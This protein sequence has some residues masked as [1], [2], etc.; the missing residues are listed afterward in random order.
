MENKGY[1]GIGIMNPKS[2]H[3]KAMGWALNLTTNAKQ[4]DQM[5]DAGF[6]MTQ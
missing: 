5:L 4:R 1:F 2:R 6:V 3:T